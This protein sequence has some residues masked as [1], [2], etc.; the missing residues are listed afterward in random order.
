M[1]AAVLTKDAF[2][3]AIGAIIDEADRLGRASDLDRVV[4]HMEPADKPSELSR[5]AAL[6]YLL[7]EEYRLRVREAAD[8]FRRWGEMKGETPS[9]DEILDIMKAVYLSRR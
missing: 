6:M 8:A 2:E 7:D 3:R 5:L 4:R 1:T 9:D